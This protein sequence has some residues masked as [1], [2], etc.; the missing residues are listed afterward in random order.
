[1]YMHTQTTVQVVT[2]VLESE[3]EYRNNLH[4]KIK[5]HIPNARRMCVRAPQVSVCA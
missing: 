1:M 2:V 3:H 4:E 5:L